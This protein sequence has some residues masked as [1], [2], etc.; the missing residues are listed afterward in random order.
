MSNPIV[1]NVAQPTT[2]LSTTKKTLTENYYC[3]ELSL[4]FNGQRNEHCVSIYIRIAT[5]TFEKDKEVIWA[6]LLEF[7]MHILQHLP[8]I[9]FFLFVVE[10]ANVSYRYQLFRLPFVRCTLD[11]IC[12]QNWAPCIGIKSTFYRL[13]QT[14]TNKSP[15]TR[16]LCKL[17]RGRPI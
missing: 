13:L 14:T 12:N 3:P 7:Q 1:E 15:F 11:I 10:F 5:M 2:T 4:Q 8:D 6:T 9:S 17:K 16:N